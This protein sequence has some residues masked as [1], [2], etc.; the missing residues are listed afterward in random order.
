ME[1]A[2]AE[3]EYNDFLIDAAEALKA[4]GRTPSRTRLRAALR[5]AKRVSLLEASR[6]VEDF[7]E[8]GGLQA[9]FGSS[10]CDVWLTAEIEK[11]R[12]LNQGIN[13][14]TLAK[15]LQRDSQT[16]DAST[17]RTPAP[18]IA[19]SLLSLADA[20]DVV[21]DYLLRYGLKPV[22][23]PYSYYGIAIVTITESL[24][25]LPVLWA[26]H[27][28]LGSLLGHPLTLPLFEFA[29]LLFIGDRLWKNWRKLRSPQ[30]WSSY[31]AARERLPLPK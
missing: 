16:F 29:L 23:G 17:S 15:R 24:L 31:D 2:A 7:S 22:L 27:F 14:T 3:G 6:A 19:R 1:K 18:R 9:R 5:D 4:S 25:F 11:A 13:S 12:R 10:P 26:V 21:D 20:I 30:R 8:R 28:A